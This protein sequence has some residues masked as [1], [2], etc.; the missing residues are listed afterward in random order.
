M[1]VPVLTTQILTGWG[2]RRDVEN[3]VLSGCEFGAVG[4]TC[5]T[6]GGVDRVVEGEGTSREL[7]LQMDE[8]RV[9]TNVHMHVLISASLC[10]CQFA[11]ISAYESVAV[12]FPRRTEFGEETF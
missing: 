12:V 10:L 8:V 2:G 1:R 11:C 7:G 9:H 4:G 6:H 3:T 5:D